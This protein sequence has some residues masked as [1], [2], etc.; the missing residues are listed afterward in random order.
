[1]D[2]LVSDINALDNG[3]RAIDIQ[4][5]I[6]HVDA[7]RIIVDQT[8]AAF[9]P[10]IDILVNNAGM[11]ER[12]PFLE[13]TVKDFD[14]SIN[15]NLR[16]AFFISQAVFPHLRR[17]G[18]IVNISSIVSRTGGPLYGVYTAPKA[19]LEAFTRSL[20]A[21]MGP[22]G[23]SANAVL[24]GLTDTD[25][26]QDITADEESANFHRGVAAATPMEGRVAS[27]S[28]IARVVGFLASSESQ[29]ITGQSIS[30]TGGLLML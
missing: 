20:A 7:P 6:A 8:L 12:K 29:W 23:H 1:M 27:P 15:V 24:P 13:T 18:R 10:S 3:A 22:H 14:A 2:K 25:M 4:A 30:A 9:G 19:G 21:F 26:L 5:D 11:S 28:D 16:G 17:P